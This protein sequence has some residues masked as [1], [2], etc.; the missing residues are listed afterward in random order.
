ME[1]FTPPLAFLR[2]D[3]LVGFLTELPT[4]VYAK[5]LSASIT[6]RYLRFSGHSNELPLCEMLSFVVVLLLGRWKTDI[7]WVLASFGGSN[8]HPTCFAQL[9]P[10]HEDIENVVIR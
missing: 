9:W 6:P 1:G 3:L 4:Y 8:Q 7:G 10:D 5:V 2:A